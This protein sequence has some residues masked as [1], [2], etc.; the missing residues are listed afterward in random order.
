MHNLRLNRIRCDPAGCLIHI[1]KRFIAGKKSFTFSGKP[2]SSR[3]LVN[4]TRQ[5]DDHIINYDD[6]WDVT[7][8]KPLYK[9]V[10]GPIWTPG[11]KSVFVHNMTDDEREQ[12]TMEQFKSLKVRQ[13][14]NG[15]VCAGFLQA[16][17]GH[18]MRL[19]EVEEGAERIRNTRRIVLNGGQLPSL[20]T[21]RLHWPTFQDGARPTSARRFPDS[22]PLKTQLRLQTLHF[23]FRN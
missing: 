16:Y 20:L 21:Y 6:P 3:T 8:G 12:I 1:V 5:R 17:A 11:R 15:F 7:G 13:P 19:I 14:K 4:R 23:N 2:A 9:V 22:D 10:E 18:P